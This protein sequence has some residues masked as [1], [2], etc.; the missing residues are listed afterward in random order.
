MKLK[1]SKI[2]VVGG[3]VGYANWMLGTVVDKMEDATLVLFT[4][5]ED[6]S[7]AFYGANKHP[8]TYCNP[9]RD[10]YEKLQFEKAQKLELPSIGICRGSQFLCTQAGGKLVQHQENP[11]AVHDITT[12][13][14]KTFPITSTHHQAQYPYSIRHAGDGKSNFKVLAWTENISR[15]HQNGEQEEMVMPLNREAEIVYYKNI[16]AL[17]IQGHPEFM[18]NQLKY[19]ESITQLQSMLNKFLYGYYKIICNRNISELV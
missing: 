1:E 13:D 14:G 11:V 6:V 17:A 5:G 12:F 18:F 8:K 15:I 9:I 4:G 3:D 2:Y 19:E 7:P 16:N 10:N